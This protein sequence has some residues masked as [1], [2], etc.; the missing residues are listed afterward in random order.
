MLQAL[1]GKMVL[2]LKRRTHICYI[3]VNTRQV[4]KLDEGMPMK[5]KLS[6]DINATVVYFQGG[7][8]VTGGGCFSA[9]EDGGDDRGDTAHDDVLN[10]C[11]LLP[12]FMI[13]PEG[14]GTNAGT[15]DRCRNFGKRG[16]RVVRAFDET[17]EPFA[18]QGT[19]DGF[20]PGGVIGSAVEGGDVVE[21]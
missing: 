20:A 6:G 11:I 3:V 8:N 10:L 2:I 7:P 21:V 19:H 15:N 9:R 18:L 17:P 12:P 4:L 5:L 16:E 14:S 1:L 13:G